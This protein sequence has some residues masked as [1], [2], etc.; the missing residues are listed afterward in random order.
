LIIGLG[1][2]QMN[3]KN[4]QISIILILFS[5]IA[6]M[7]L[8]LTSAQAAKSK[9]FDEELQKEIFKPFKG[10]LDQLMKRRVIRIL[11]TYNKTNY[12]FDGAHTRGV[13]V[14]VLNKYVK[15]LN[16]GYKKGHL[17]AHAIY[18]P[19]TRD[20]LI[21]Y[22]VQGK[23]DI[24]AANLTITSS[25]KKKV[26]FTNPTASGVKELLVTSANAPKIGKLEDLSGKKVLVRKSS[27]Y[28]QS[29]LKLNAKFKKK[30]LKPVKIVEASED[31]ETEDILELVNSDMFKI[32][33]ADDYLA[34]FWSKIFK[35]IKVHPNIALRTGADIAWAVRKSSKK[36]KASL[37]RFVKT[38]KKG[39]L[40]GNVLLKRY[41]KNTKFVRD[42]FTPEHMKRFQATVRYFKKYASKYSFDH[43]MIT[44]LAYQESKLDQKL[45]SKA[46]AVGVMQILPTTAKADP[47]GI[48][49]ISK[50]E[51][52]IH[53]GTKYL[54]HIYNSYFKNIKEMTRLD[55]MLMT[56]ASYN[57]GPTR[58]MKLRRLTRKMGLNQNK[59]F[60]NVEI[61][62]A[63]DIGRE[64]VQYV[65]NIF[66]YYFAY[67]QGLAK[68][69]ADDQSHIKAQ[70]KAKSK[71][72]A[73][74]QK[75][76]K[77]K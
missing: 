73:A 56:F 1:D 63:K 42:A 69:M 51:P 13:T 26:D 55:K 47:V 36:L 43:L 25:R 74:A 30:K 64:T 65:S 49:G 11:V 57:A 31:M 21:P 37:N 2:Q 77:K 15:E 41:F 40:Y 61:A 22:L 12:F 35:N 6:L 46:G 68:E 5:I 28:Y 8:S 18:I 76:K 62:A 67:Q 17:Q 45:K 66:K 70:Q 58:V 48:P 32:T 4:H 34:N 75:K 50:L 27:S 53:A 9:S 14:E 39:T 3:R 33:V 19:V 20:Q 44:A 54:R 72:K 29:L 7:G 60:N 71:K 23:G 16:K 24:A 59:W 10:D 38:H 52:N